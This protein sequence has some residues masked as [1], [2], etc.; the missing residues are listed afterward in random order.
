MVCMIATMKITALAE[1][2]DDG[3]SFLFVQDILNL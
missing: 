3:I 2:E 1:G